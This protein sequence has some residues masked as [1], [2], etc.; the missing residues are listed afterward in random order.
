VW[1]G[2]DDIFKTAIGGNKSL[3]HKTKLRGGMNID[4]RSTRRSS[5]LAGEVAAEVENLFSGL[6]CQLSSTMFEIVL[7]ANAYW[8]RPRVRVRRLSIDLPPL[9]NASETPFIRSQFKRALQHQRKSNYF[10]LVSYNNKNSCIPSY[11]IHNP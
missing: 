9:F 11:A 1:R 2:S 3:I 5:S 4:L 7:R 6:S 8:Y 10:V